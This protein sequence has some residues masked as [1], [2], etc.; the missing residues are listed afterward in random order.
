MKNDKLEKLIADV[1]TGRFGTKNR[2]ELISRLEGV[3]LEES[4]KTRNS[5]LLRT[6]TEYCNLKPQER[7]WQALRNWSGAD[8]IQFVRD[9]WDA[10]TFYWEQRDEFEKGVDEE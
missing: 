6:F 10:D 2:S 3:Y 7:F 4:S 9:K 5:E 8:F 1:F